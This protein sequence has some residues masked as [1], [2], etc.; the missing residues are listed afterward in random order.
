M[1]AFL[2]FCAALTALAQPA[3]AAGITYDC[4]TAANH[5]SELSLPAPGV[6]FTVTGA[7]QLNALAQSTTYVPLAR[8]QIAASTAPGKSPDA[9][10]GFSLEALPANAKQTPSGSPAVQMLTWNSAGKEDE[11]LPLSL[12]TKPGTV[13]AFTLTYDGSNV[14]LNLGNEAKSFRMKAAEPVVRIICSTG[15]FLFTNLVIQPSR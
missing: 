8:V 9:Y 5:F 3:T 2:G 14:S 15:E 4:D 12:L 10:A 1:K 11:V 7:V 6:P 13:Q